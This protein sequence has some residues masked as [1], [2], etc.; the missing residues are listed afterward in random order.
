MSTAALPPLPSRLTHEEADAYVR[1]CQAARAAGPALRGQPVWPVDASALQRFD[2][3]ALAALLAVGRMAHQRGARLQV[4]GMPD[5]LKEL[6]ALYG[7]GEL[8]PA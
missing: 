4:Q 7:V 2:S 3:A 1:Q 8:L 6:A 5:R